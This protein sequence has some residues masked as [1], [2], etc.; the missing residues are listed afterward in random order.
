MLKS[1]KNIVIG[2]RLK[3]I[4]HLLQLLNGLVFRFETP[5]ENEIDQDFNIFN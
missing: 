5:F 4:D 2:S 1:W 3:M